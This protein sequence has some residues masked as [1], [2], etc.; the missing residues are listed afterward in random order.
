MG[1]FRLTSL[2]TYDFYRWVKR[3]G[4]NDEY[5]FWQSLSGLS[6]GTVVD[7]MNEYL[8]SLGY[9][10]H[11]DD[12]FHQFLIDQVAFAGGNPNQLRTL[13]DLANFLY[14]DG[15]DDGGGAVGVVDDDGNTVTD[16]DGNVV[17]D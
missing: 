4:F 2:D 14:D 6:R 3:L 13:Y 15:F 1:S 12:K 8:T 16:D 9:T 10:G 17:T 7:H 11:P 5:E